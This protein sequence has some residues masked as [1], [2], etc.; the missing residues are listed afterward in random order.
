MSG[1]FGITSSRFHTASNNGISAIGF[2]ISLEL[3]IKSNRPY[4]CEF[5]FQFGIRTKGASKLSTKVIFNY[6]HHLYLLYSFQFPAL[7]ITLL[8]FLIS[9]CISIV[10]F[11]LLI[12]FR[13]KYKI[14]KD[15]K[16][17]ILFFKK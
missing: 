10:F 1:F 15:I 8:Q 6:V 11:I 9:I 16:H 12:S 4:H 17:L 7:W 5:P 3:Y 13:R 2:K 14:S